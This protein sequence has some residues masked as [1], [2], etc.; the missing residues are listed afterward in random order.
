MVDA[1]INQD[2]ALSSQ[3]VVGIIAVSIDYAIRPGKGLFSAV[4]EIRVRVAQLEGSI[5][6][7]RKRKGDRGSNVIYR[8]DGS[9]LLI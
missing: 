5:V 4:V 7:V 3:L 1:E 9:Y 6:H 8:R 2:R